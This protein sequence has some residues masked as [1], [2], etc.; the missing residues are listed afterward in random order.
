MINMTIV[1][2]VD[3]LIKELSDLKYK[4]TSCEE[5]NEI[6]KDILALIRLKDKVV[7]Y[8]DRKTNHM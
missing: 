4:V 6:H 3:C 1:D 8:N 5:W 7:K 2:Y